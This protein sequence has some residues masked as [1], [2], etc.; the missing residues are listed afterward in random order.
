MH[1]FVG[2]IWKRPPALIGLTLYS[3]LFRV[4]GWPEKLEL[5]P[6]TDSGNTYWVTSI[7]LQ[8]EAEEGKFIAVWSF[9]V[10][11][12]IMW[13]LEELSFLKIFFSH[14][15]FTTTTLHLP[16]VKAD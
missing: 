12:S 6:T 16:R 8:V 7:R 2:N 3:L 1:S 14:T 4:G 13:F 10:N 11:E 9:L 15:P 5:R